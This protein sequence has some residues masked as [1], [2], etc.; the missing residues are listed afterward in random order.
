MPRR[1][2]PPLL[3][4]LAVEI[5]GAARDLRTLS[6][7][8]QSTPLGKC[9]APVSTLAEQIEG[10][11]SRRGLQSELHVYE[12]RVGMRDVWIFELTVFTPDSSEQRKLRNWR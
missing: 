5:E 1:Y 6:H 4:R 8:A 9:P 12:G 7:E 2:W 3:T 11:A 10:V